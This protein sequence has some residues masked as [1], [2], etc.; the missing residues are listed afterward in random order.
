MVIEFV[1][2]PG[3][4]KTFIADQ[5]I[6]RLQ[7]KVKIERGTFDHLDTFRKK[8]GKFLFA[9]CCYVHSFEISMTVTKESLRLH[10]N[11]L[12]AMRDTFNILYFITRY[13]QVNK[14]LVKSE[15]TVVVFDQGL[16]QACLSISVHGGYSEKIL[17]IIREKTGRIVHIGVSPEEAAKRLRKRQHQGSRSQK[18][19]VSIDGL[20][21]EKKTLQKILNT[22][23][24][25]T[26]N[27]LQLDNN[28]YGYENKVEQIIDWIHKEF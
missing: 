13:R 17:N 15:R 12:E 26:E 3:S 5:L 16:A 11:R 22:L 9:I 10:N 8:A 7:G 20:E 25:G 24:L 21:N 19:G 27:Y 23:H 18:K 2:I 1:G 6:K 14:T 28:N 4:G